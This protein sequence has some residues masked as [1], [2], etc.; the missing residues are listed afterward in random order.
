MTPK[1]ID[2]LASARIFV[3]EPA[4]VERREGADAGTYLVG[5]ASVFDQWTTLYEDEDLVMREVV[6]RGAFAAAIAERQD[7]RALFN[8]DKN[9]VLGRTTSGTLSLR[10][11]DRGLLSETR[12]TDSPTIRD[13]V[14]TP[15]QR[16][17]ITGMSF[18][19]SPRNKGTGQNT[20]ESGDGKVVI[21]R[22]GE[23]ITMTERGTQ[24]V[25][26]REL[27][28]VDLYDVSPVT[29]P[30]YQGT[31]VGLRAADVHEFKAEVRRH[32]DAMKRVESASPGWSA[33]AAMRVR[34]AEAG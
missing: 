14:T 23:R 1:Q 2:A 3:D 20:N 28:S 32:L 19:F 6:R 26:E 33:I 30:A 16:G 7:V 29:Y 34:L 15:I 21:R 11:L 13:L 24:L 27:L 5:F 10:E 12:L 4:R 18:G 17:D 8:H 31:S 9:F 22:G 25:W